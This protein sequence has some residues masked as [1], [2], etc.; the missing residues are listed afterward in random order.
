MILNGMLPKGTLIKTVQIKKG[1][2]LQDLAVMY[3]YVK[4]KSDHK[5]IFPLS[6]YEFKKQLEILIKKYQIV[7][8]DELNCPSNKP[9][10]VLTFDDGTKD[11]YD[12]AFDILTK[13]GLPAYFSFMS[14][15][16]LENKIPIFHLIHTVLSGYPDI[17]IYEKLKTYCDIS[18]IPG[19][20]EIYSYET[21]QYRR[22]IKWILNFILSENEARM[23]LEGLFSEIY[24]DKKKFLNDYYLNKDELRIMHR[25]GMT[26]GVHCHHHIPYH[27]D[28]QRF[29]LEEIAPCKK[30]LMNEVGIIPRW[31][32]PAFGGG[33]KLKDMK[34]DL[35]TILIE[36]GFKG[37]FTTV[38]G[39]INQ[40]EPFWFNRFDCNDLPPK[41]YSSI[42]NF[43]SK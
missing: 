7:S 6:P 19:S 10:C 39:F 15:P 4:D 3:H 9:R 41:K 18:S 28:T 42:W 35:T 43:L 26:I 20:I 12:I 29:Y 5:G 36:N 37:A 17:E 11:Q 34:R 40:N 27:R 32:T 21:N 33:T 30:Y 8:V 13:K 16:V 1:L 24:S 23:F 22:Y 2:L 31:Y 25:A 38:S 14:G